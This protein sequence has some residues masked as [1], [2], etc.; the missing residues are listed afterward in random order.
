VIEV[1]ALNWP[2]ERRRWSRFYAERLAAQLRQAVALL[3]DAPPDRRRSHFDTCLSL[4]NATAARPD[5]V[6][7]WLALVDRL[8]P[9][10]V[11]WGQ[12]AAWLGVLQQAADRAATTGQPARQA[13]YLAYAADLRLN[14]GQLA[15]ALDTARQAMHQATRHRAAWPLAVAGSHAAAALRA[16]ARY[17]EA[18]ALVD[19]TRSSLGQLPPPQPLARAVLAAALLDLEQMDLHRTFKRLDAALALGEG[20][21]AR[22]SAA[23]GAD[24]HDLANAYVR[25]ATIVWVSGQYAAAADDL[26]RAAA[27]FRQ[28]GDA[29]Q[30]TFAEANLGTV[31]YSMSR[32]GPAEAYKLAA[33]RAAEEVNARA[34]LVSEFGDLSTIY[35]GLGRME[36]ALDYTNRMIALADE[37][38]NDAELS[39]GRGNRGYVLL[40][41]GRYEEALADI[42]FGLDLYRRQ[43][44]LEG[45]IVTTVD[46]ILYLRGTGQAGRAAQLAQENYEAAWREAFPHLHIVTA[47]CLALFLPPPQQEALLRQTLAL[48][49]QHARPMDEAGCLFSLAAVVADAGER[50]ALFQQGAALLRQM[51][52]P[53]WLDGRSVDD[54]PLLP[55]TI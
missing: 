43:G 9:Q 35:I 5:L 19:Q 1:M 25:R 27:L 41:L 47:R 26:Q 34:Q 29:L 14:T 2:D 38:G 48:A 10:P 54:P 11:R 8:H 50:A 45:T 40:A 17:D 7:P 51:G 18:Q 28:A 12:W 3:D 31:Y 22:L 4:L 52:C 16:M 55:M 49:R 21:I 44:R 13:E 24:P 33:V 42:E 37:L 6:E 39:R 23:A 20:L 15:A 32:Y 53:G 30:A 46:L 36:A